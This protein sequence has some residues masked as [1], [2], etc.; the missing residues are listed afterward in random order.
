MYPNPCVSFPPLLFPSSFSFF[1]FLP[2]Y[3]VPASFA[4]SFHPKCRDS[5]SFGLPLTKQYKGCATRTDT[6]SLCPNPEKLIPPPPPRSIGLSGH[7]L[8]CNKMPALQRIILPFNGPL[9]PPRPT[10]YLDSSVEWKN[11]PLPRVKLEDLVTYT[12][13]RVIKAISWELTGQSSS[14]VL[15]GPH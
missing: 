6:A 8:V 1:F 13:R 11:V 9:P 4:K 3:V 14:F 7:R 2:K 5:E 15:K 10:G 12:R